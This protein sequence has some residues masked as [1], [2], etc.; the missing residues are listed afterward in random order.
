MDKDVVVCVHNGIILNYEQEFIWVS[1]DE[2]DEPGAYYTEQNKS[3]SIAKP[4]SIVSLNLRN[5]PWLYNMFFW[6][7][8]GGGVPLQKFKNTLFPN[9]QFQHLSFNLT[10]SYM[11]TLQP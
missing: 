7:E 9:K 10:F 1:S 11:N 6:D 4:A 2:V 5:R 8:I 3:E